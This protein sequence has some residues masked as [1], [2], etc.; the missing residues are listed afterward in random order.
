MP[1]QY[2]A[3][4]ATVFEYDMLTLPAYMTQGRPEST[5]YASERLPQVEVNGENFYVWHDVR[6]GSDVPALVLALRRGEPFDHA[7]EEVVRSLY[8]K[9]GANHFL[10][11]T[12]HEEIVDFM[13]R[14]ERQLLGGNAETGV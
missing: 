1:Q 4:L 8:Y 7:V 10:P 2:G 11:S 6:L 14:L 5:R 12:N 3:L 13:G 9:V